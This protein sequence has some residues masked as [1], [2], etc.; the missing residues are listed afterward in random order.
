MARQ[1]KDEDTPEA[2]AK[3]LQGLFREAAISLRGTA[4]DL[5]SFRALRAC[6]FEPLGTQELAA[7]KLEL[8]IATL[9]RHLRDGE[10]KM[11]EILWAK[12]K[13]AR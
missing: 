13:S 4:S 5:K 3:V 10:Q 6:Y 7:E 9:R 11:V 1:L 12:E 8:G 2:R